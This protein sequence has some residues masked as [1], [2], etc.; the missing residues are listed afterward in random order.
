MMWL[1]LAEARS[2]LCLDPFIPWRFNACPSVDH[3]PA[4]SD[5]QGTKLHHRQE[6]E[7]RPRPARGQEVL[8][9]VPE[10]YCPPGNQVPWQQ[11]SSTLGADR[12]RGVAPLVAQRSPKPRVGRSRRSPP[13]R[14]SVIEPGPDRSRS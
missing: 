7:E 5:L 8:P 4:V 6:Q 9:T 14:L 1:R 11:P 2:F 10:A 13:T 3:H 12:P